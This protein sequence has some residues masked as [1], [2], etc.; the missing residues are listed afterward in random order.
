MGLAGD[1]ICT[2]DATMYPD[3]ANNGLKESNG[4]TMYGMY[5]MYGIN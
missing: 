5:R 1:H 2:I 3:S 4:I